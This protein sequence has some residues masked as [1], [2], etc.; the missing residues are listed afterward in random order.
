MCRRMVGCWSWGNPVLGSSHWAFGSCGCCCYRVPLHQ[1]PHLP[2]Y[3]TGHSA[4]AELRWLPS[5]LLLASGDPRLC[6]EGTRSP[7]PSSNWAA[8][9]MNPVGVWQDCQTQNHHHHRRHHHHHYHLQTRAGIG[10]Q[11]PWC[12][13][14]SDS[15]CTQGPGARHGWPRRHGTEG[16]LWEMLAYLHR[17]VV[18]PALSAGTLA[19]VNW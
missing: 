18:A 7:Q 2:G 5:V 12:T 17:L 6:G 9:H 11:G 3:D 4:R 13:C 14:G 8:H 16:P 1:G 10:T 19:P 15:P